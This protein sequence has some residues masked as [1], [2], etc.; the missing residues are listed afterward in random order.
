MCRVLLLGLCAGLAGC[1]TYLSAATLSLAAAQNKPPL[2][3]TYLPRTPGEAH[4]LLVLGMHHSMTSVTT[5]LLVDRGFYAGDETSE[6]LIRKDNP[7][8]YWELKKAV[9]ADQACLNRHDRAPGRAYSWLGYGF[10]Q[11]LPAQDALWGA[12]KLVLQH[13]EQQAGERPIVVKDPRMSLLADAWLKHARDPVCLV[14]V[15]DPEDSA[16]RFLA[17]YM[18]HGGL[19]ARQWG[20]VWEQYTWRAIASCVRAGAPLVVVRHEDAASAPEE[21]VE[22]IVAQLRGLGFRNIMPPGQRGLTPAQRAKWIAGQTK[23]VAKWRAA[24]GLLPLLA[25]G[26]SVLSAQG[27]VLWDLVRT[28]SYAQLPDLVRDV[29]PPTWRDLGSNPTEAYVTMLLSLKGPLADAVVVLGRSIMAHDTSRRLCVLVP[30][31]LA[32]NERFRDRGWHLVPTS[33]TSLSEYAEI[34]NS[35]APKKLR[36]ALLIAPGSMLLQS[37]QGMFA[38]QTSWTAGNGSV[39]LLVLSDPALSQSAQPSVDAISQMLVH[40]P[41]EDCPDGPWHVSPPAAA[42]TGTCSSTAFGARWLALQSL[43]GKASQLADE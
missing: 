40:W 11:E 30:Y 35:L 29:N 13:L 9:A 10:P 4:T 25:E 22:Q 38:A 41:T 20:S 36:K 24:R 16:F 2:P 5:K 31:H 28:A 1:L 12:A 3:A 8:K 6:L 33:A 26:K 43:G 23:A 19:D 27:Q 42:A 14:L 37:M 32:F 18:A 34:A 15:R 21:T 7:L 39:G 17:S